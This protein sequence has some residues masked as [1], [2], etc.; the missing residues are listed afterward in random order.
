MP[1]RILFQY[2]IFP[3]R[4]FRR[5]LKACGIFVVA[6]EIASTLVFILECIPIKDYWLSYGSGR[7]ITDGGR[8]INLIRFLLVNGSI[9]TVT[10][11]TLL[12]MVIDILLKTC[13]KLL[14][15]AIAITSALESPGT[16]STEMHPDCHLRHWS[17]V[18]RRVRL[19]PWMHRT[20][21]GL[22]GSLLSVWYG[23]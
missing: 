13:Y 14:I 21:I 18:R 5:I 20:E 22:I 2:R 7:G 23:W 16:N 11:F 12:L 1:T 10:D 17:Y 3:V 8:C 9:N 15:R 19:F 6:F 4:S